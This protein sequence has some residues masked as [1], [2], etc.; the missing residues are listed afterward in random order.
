[1]KERILRMNDIWQLTQKDN[2]IIL[3]NP[4]QYSP[5][6]IKRINAKKITWSK[7]SKDPQAV[8]TAPSLW[9]RLSKKTRVPLKMKSKHAHKWNND[10][11]LTLQLSEKGVG[12]KDS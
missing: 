12:L 2:L 6:L 4:D 8:L 1:M 9:D 10:F 11:L 7:T 5:E 3:G